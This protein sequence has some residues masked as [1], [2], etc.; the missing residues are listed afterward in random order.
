MAY[1][2]FVYYFREIPDDFII[3]L[4]R[5]EGAANDKHIYIYSI[6]LYSI[7]KKLVTA[8]S[9]MKTINQNYKEKHF[10]KQFFAA[11]T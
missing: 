2:I 3:F 6:Y 1:M 9:S 5:G 7:F 10:S 4:M 8:I 11:Y